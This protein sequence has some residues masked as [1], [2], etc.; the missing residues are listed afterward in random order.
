MNVITATEFRNNQRKY[1]DLAE[2]EPVLITR[3]GKTPIA[4]TPVRIK[5]M[6]TEKEMEA[7]KEGFEAYKNGNCTTVADPQDVWQCIQ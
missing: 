6:P 1:F 2:K 5:D 3:A 4:L 7:I